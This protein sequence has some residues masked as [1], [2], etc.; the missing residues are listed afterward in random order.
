MVMVSDSLH[1]HLAGRLFLRI[2]APGAGRA[3]HE[4]T[5]GHGTSERGGAKELVGRREAIPCSLELQPYLRPT[6]HPTVYSTNHISTPLRICCRLRLLYCGVW[7]PTSLNS[8]RSR[9]RSS[10]R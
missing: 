5:G 8:S 10:G 4:T 2:Y 6:R 1:D 3:L 9:T 7:S